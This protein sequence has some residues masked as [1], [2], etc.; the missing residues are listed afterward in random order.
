MGYD[1]VFSF[2]TTGSMS[3]C[4]NS[5]RKNISDIVTKL[6]NE[7]PEIRIGIIAHGDYCDEGTSYLMKQVDLTTDKEKIVNFVNTVE[8][9]GGGDYPE[10]YEYV[11]NKAQTLSWDSNSLRVLVMIGDAVPHNKN[12]NPHKLDWRNEVDEL[13]K[14]GIN[15]YSV[16]ALYSGKGDSYTFYRQMATKTNGY[17]LFL[18]QFSY[19]SDAF[20]AICLK[21]HSNEKVEQYEQEITSKLGVLTKS[22]KR[23]FDT[24]L[25]REIKDDDYNEKITSYNED[26]DKITPC[27]PAKYQL[28]K[29]DKELSIKDFVLS[30]DLKFKTGKGFY[31][32]TKPESISSKK[33]IVLMKKD[34]GEL[35]EG[36]KARSIAKIN[37][38]NK[39]YKPSDLADYK[40]FI[41]STSVSRKLVKGTSFLY[42]AEDWV[43]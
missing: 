6:F 13:A 14:M 19:I 2:D 38:D 24:L 11:L 25:N 15:I 1:I 40:V 16:Q 21:Q 39:K 17:H 5:V 4:I 33:L 26:D 18:D 35:F 42:E 30:N 7:I 8:N 34:T 12:D 9:T 22:M 36:R 23:F 10:A 20:T 28:L 29:V 32:F 31:E 27:P 43:A 41:Q 3:S 37:D